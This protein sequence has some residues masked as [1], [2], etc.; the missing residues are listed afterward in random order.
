MGSLLRSSFLASRSDSFVKTIRT[1]LTSNQSIANYLAYLIN[2]LATRDRILAG[3]AT[4]WGVTCSAKVHRPLLLGL[5]ARIRTP[6]SIGYNVQIM[7]SPLPS[8]DD[9][10]LNSAYAN[11]SLLADE[12]W[13]YD[14]ED[15]FRKLNRSLWIKVR[16]CA[17]K[18]LFEFTGG[19]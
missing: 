1:D 14:R 4:G 13:S 2:C 19:G 17:F 7:I 9:D 18:H 8:Y 15:P 3:G 5:S 12:A 11:I 10:F 6:R 16:Y